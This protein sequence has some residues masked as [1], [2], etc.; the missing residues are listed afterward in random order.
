MPSAPNSELLSGLIPFVIG[1]TGHRDLRPEDLSQLRD[2]VKQV[3]QELAARLKATPLLLLSGLA[4]GSDQLIAEVAVSLGIDLFVVL[5]MPL[6]I[7]LD[8]MG[9]AGRQNFQLLYDRATIKIDLPLNGMPASQLEASE[10]VRAD[11]YH[12]LAIFLANHSQALIALWDGME[13]QTGGTAEVVDFVRNGAPLRRGNT[14][15]RPSRGTVYHIVTPRRRHESRLSNPFELHLLRAEDQSRV[16]SAS[17]ASSLEENIDRFNR[18]AGRLDVHDPLLH[19]LMPEAQKETAWPYLRRIDQCYSYANALAMK[20]QRWRRRYLIAILALSLTG[21]GGLEVHADIIHQWNWLW[22]VYPVSILCAF[23]AYLASKKSRIENRFHESR[24]LAEAL[25]VQFYWELGGVHEAVSNHYIFHDPSEIGWILA[26]TRGL[27]LFCQDPP[28]MSSSQES[29]NLRATSDHWVIDQAA[30]F[31]RSS[32]KQH[33]AVER[34]ERVTNAALILVFLFSLFVA[35]VA[36]LP[37][38]WQLAWGEMIKGEWREK[39]HFLIVMP[40]VALG[41]FKIWIE[42]AAYDEQARNYRRMGHLFSLGAETL[43]ECLE[44]GDLPQA[45]ATVK[46]LGIRA[47]EEN[48]I[49]LLMHRER[50]LK[51]FSGG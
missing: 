28:K 45:M 41:L 11:R 4:E 47:L 39:I 26:A 5:P 23:L 35:I 29:A 30:W 49:W 13:G 10:S 21:F 2:R 37:G 7:Y 20:Y 22:L 3:L 51:V 34:L 36:L 50:P 40:S 16:Q 6:D 31:D 42:Q 19:S 27:S 43:D 32:K 46:D 38:G 17:A 8:T 1:A 48:S 24:A 12:A 15:G 14:K 33:H 9:T 44:A 25:R 18:D